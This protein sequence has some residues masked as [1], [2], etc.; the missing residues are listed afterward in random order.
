MRKP[1][2]SDLTDAQWALIEPLIPVYE[3]GRPREVDMREVLNTNH[4]KGG[5]MLTR[6]RRA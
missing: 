1:Y 6:G 4:P 2:P 3:V 5:R